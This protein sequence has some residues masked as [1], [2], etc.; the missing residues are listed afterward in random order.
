LFVGLREITATHL[1]TKC[2]DFL[3]SHNSFPKITQRLH[4]DHVKSSRKDNRFAETT[5][6]DYRDKNQERESEENTLLQAQDTE[7]SC[8][9]GKVAEGTDEHF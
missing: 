2:P 8:V 5:N 6:R 3:N 1:R 4:Q 7:F 9:R